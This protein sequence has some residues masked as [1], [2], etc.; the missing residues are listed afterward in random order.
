MNDL[1][2]IGLNKLREIVCDILEYSKEDN[3]GRMDHVRPH[4]KAKTIEALTV[5]SALEDNLTNKK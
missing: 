4:L 3:N 2:K 1:E 5:I